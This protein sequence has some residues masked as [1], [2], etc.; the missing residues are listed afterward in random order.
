MVPLTLLNSRW[1][2]ER[3]KRGLS[4]VK[5][6][7]NA[8]CPCLSGKK[9]KKCCMLKPDLPHNGTSLATAGGKQL[10]QTDDISQREMSRLLERAQQKGLVHE[11]VSLEPSP[12]GKMSGVL[13]EFLDPLMDP[14]FSD[15]QYQSLI[16]LGALAWNMS[17]I[18]AAQPLEREQLFAMIKA[19]VAMP[20]SEHEDMLIETVTWLMQRK[21]DFYAHIER[22]IVEF[23]VVKTDDGLRVN[24]ISTA[25]DDPSGA[26]HV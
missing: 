1:G 8:P 10:A 6:G 4:P 18:T 3:T 12:Y 24:V 25:V 19:K 9:Y 7:R 23:E 21:Q 16:A 2:S 20:D 11:A 22:L 13:L 5:I 17:L 26:A 14:N 15:D